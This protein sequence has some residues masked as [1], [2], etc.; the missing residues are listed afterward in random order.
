[1]SKVTVEFLVFSNATVENSVTLQINRLTAAEFLAKYYRPLLDMLQ[2]DVDTGD[3]F[4]IFSIGE[5]DGNLD[6]YLAMETPKGNFH[7]FFF[8]LLFLLISYFFFRI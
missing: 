4:T 5:S 7:F 3:T 6:I 2:D 8:I 1:M